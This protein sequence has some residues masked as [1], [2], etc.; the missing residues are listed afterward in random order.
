MI[1]LVVNMKFSKI[2]KELRDSKGISQR[3]LAKEIGISQSSVHAYE[4][5]E[6]S[7][8]IDVLLKLAK[9]FD[10][11]ADYLLGLSDKPLEGIPE[12]IKNKL[13]KFEV[14]EKENQKYKEIIN[15][16]KN[17]ISEI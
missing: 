2:L 16:I 15:Q 12:H 7:P 3:Q 9:Y 11:S 13:D 17:L 14:L 4:A 1:T 10:V 6:K 8:T 5:G